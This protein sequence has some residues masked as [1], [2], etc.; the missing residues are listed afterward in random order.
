MAEKKEINIQ[1][2]IKHLSEKWG[3]QSC[4]MCGSNDWN[5]SDTIYELRKYHGGNLIIGGG[6]ILPIVPIICNNCGNSIFINAII[7]GAIDRPNVEP[8]NK[9]D[10]E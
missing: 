7:S 1:N 2:V 10:N 8:S 6:P 5:V 9:S 4:P 3:N